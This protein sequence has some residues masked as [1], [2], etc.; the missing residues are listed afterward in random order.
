MI[1]FEKIPHPNLFGLSTPSIVSG[2]RGSEVAFENDTRRTKTLHV[3]FT[4]VCVVGPTDSNFTT[5]EAGPTFGIALRLSR[6]GES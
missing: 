3:C 6:G 5:I 4:F 2:D 1:C